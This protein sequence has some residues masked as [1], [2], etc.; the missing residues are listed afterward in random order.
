MATFHGSNNSE[1]NTRQGIWPFDVFVPQIEGSGSDDVIYSYAG[2]DI[3]LGG[4]GNDVI[5]GDRSSASRT[6]V[7]FH[8]SDTL[9]GGSGN[10]VIHGDGGDDRL[11]GETDNDTLYG[12]DGNDKL[13]GG[14]NSGGGVDALYGDA[15]DDILYGDDSETTGGADILIGGSGNDQLFGRAGNDILQGQ[16]SSSL[17]S[18]LE[19]DE[20]TGGL[21][22]DTFRVAGLYSHGR[23][24]D[25]AMIMDWNQ[26]GAQDKLD[27][28]NPN[29]IQLFSVDSNTFNVYQVS[30]VGGLIGGTSSE[31]VAR[32]D[33][34]TL[35]GQSLFNNIMANL[36]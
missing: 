29:A 2:D 35:S 33:S 28:S 17:L 23:N 36:I 27:V 10:D 1:N 3:V 31:L 15:G 30:E 19:R 4:G 16:S 34:N 7:G 6:S 8:G 18:L 14:N 26:G 11:Y 24:N 13:Y 25:Y 22:S 12:G 20:L 32:I 21:G 9:K 5:Y